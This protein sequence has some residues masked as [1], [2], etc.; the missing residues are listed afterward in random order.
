MKLFGWFEK[1]ISEH[2]SAAAL[3]DYLALVKEQKANFEAENTI[4]KATL[5]KCQAEKIALELKISEMQIL[6]DDATKQIKA[7]ESVRI[8]LRDQ[9]QLLRRISQREAMNQDL[10]QQLRI[11][12]IGF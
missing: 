10:E 7:L 9:N 11:K 5:Q 4:L 8:A 3:R 12:S 6:Q 2:G 1:W